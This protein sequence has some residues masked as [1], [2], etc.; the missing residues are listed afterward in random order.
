MVRKTT[1]APPQSGATNKD[2]LLPNTQQSENN[3]Y[4]PVIGGQVEAES[5]PYLDQESLRSGTVG[6]PLID[7]AI[8]T[9]IQVEREAVCKVFGLSERVSKGSRVYW[10][11]KIPLKNNKEYEIVVAQSP[12]MA[13]VAAALLT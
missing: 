8:I 3:I 4:P 12:D 9:A 6:T 11:G 10:R 5:T 1:Q 13:N 7:F 2:A